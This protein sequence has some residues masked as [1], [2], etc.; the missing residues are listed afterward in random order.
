M[1]KR[2]GFLVTFHDGLGISFL[3]ILEVL[4]VYM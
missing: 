3:Y 2:L 1:V 4:H